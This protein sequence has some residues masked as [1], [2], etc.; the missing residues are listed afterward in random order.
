MTQPGHNQRGREQARSTVAAL[1][2]RATGRRGGRRIVEFEFLW[3]DALLRAGQRVRLRREA[4]GIAAGD[5]GV[6]VG[7]YARAERTVV[8]RFEVAVVEVQ[9]DALEF[10]DPPDPAA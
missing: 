8:V 6:V 10:V 4:P 9:P 7:F 2:A 3:G 1:P 5:E